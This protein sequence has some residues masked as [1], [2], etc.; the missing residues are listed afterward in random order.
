MQ[1]TVFGTDKFEEDFA[2]YTGAKYC[3]VNSGTSALA[4]TI[5][6]V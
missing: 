3:V 5:L 2:E 6:W 4:V 1:I